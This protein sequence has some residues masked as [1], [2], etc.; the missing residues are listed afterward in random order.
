[1]QSAL[2]CFVLPDYFAD[3]FGGALVIYICR[4]PSVMTDLPVDLDALLA[5]TQFRIRA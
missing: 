1:V 4:K 3:A 5:H 2:L